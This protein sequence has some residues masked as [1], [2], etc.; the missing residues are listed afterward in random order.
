MEL[1]ALAALFA[2]EE[3]GLEVGVR[4]C[5]RVLN[6]EH[7]RHRTP[8]SQTGAQTATTLKWAISPFAQGFDV[9]P[10]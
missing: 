7:R 5:R 9:K 1:G 4:H 10:G 6:I 3:G 2:V 8:G